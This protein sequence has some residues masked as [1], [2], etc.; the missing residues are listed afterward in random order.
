MGELRDVSSPDARR[1]RV[2][3]RREVGPKT[4]ALLGMA[5]LPVEARAPSW[6]DHLR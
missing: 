5:P 3:P 1:R 4:W 6:K 2:V